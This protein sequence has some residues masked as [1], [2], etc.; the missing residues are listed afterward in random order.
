MARVLLK[1]RSAPSLLSSTT[2]HKSTGREAPAA[3]RRKHP[4]YLVEASSLFSLSAQLV[5]PA[6]AS[7]WHLSRGQHH[8]RPTSA[9]GNDNF[10]NHNIWHSLRIE[11][12]RVRVPAHTPL[13]R[14][15]FVTVNDAN[16]HHIGT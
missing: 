6:N 4:R 3:L 15:L 7:T 9:A 1:L 16:E 5:S 13:T 2:C 11:I 12:A 14:E 10:G 8:H